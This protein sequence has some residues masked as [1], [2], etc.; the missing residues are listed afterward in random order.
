MSRVNDGL[1]ARNNF[2]DAGE[3]SGVTSGQTGGAIYATFTNTTDI[4][5]NRFTKAPDHPDSF[6]GVKGH[7]AADTR[8][9]DSTVNVNFS[10]EF[11]FENDLRLETLRNFR[12]GVVSAPKFAGGP[13][14]ML[15][16]SY[17]IYFYNNNYFDETCSIEGPR[18]GMLIRENLS[19]F[20]ADDDGGSI[21]SIFGS[22]C[23]PLSSGPT[24]VRKQQYLELWPRPV[25]VGPGAERVRVHQQPRHREHHH[26]AAHREPLRHQARRQQ[27]R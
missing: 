19:D 2:I 4:H 8:I 23:S 27:Q 18:N 21:V 17:D 16:G 9:F 11:P 13:P 7:K 22:N 10:I 26:Y 15:G 1:I 25:L 20:R 14:S 3:H 5:S 24:A 6:F 12:T